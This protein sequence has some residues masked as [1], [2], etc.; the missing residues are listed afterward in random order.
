MNRSDNFYFNRHFLIFIIAVLAYIPSLIFFPF[1]FYQQKDMGY[2]PQYVLAWLFWLSLLAY[3]LG[4]FFN[5]K[6]KSK[7][8]KIG[9][10][11]A[12]H[13]VDFFI[14]FLLIFN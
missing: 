11:M 4:R 2:W 14:A 9:I 10:Y 7:L 12:T 8:A 1:F 6:K 5:S 13:T 3:I